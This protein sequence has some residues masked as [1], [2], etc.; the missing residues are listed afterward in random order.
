MV[1]YQL[2]QKGSALLMALF[3]TAISTIITMGLIERQR[4]DIHRSELMLSSNQTYLYTQGAVVWAKHFLSTD[5]YPNANNN[6]SNAESD[7]TSNNTTTA[8]ANRANKIIKWPVVMPT[9]KLP[10]GSTVNAMIMDAQGFYNINNVQDESEQAYFIRL[11]KIILPS[12]AQ[13]NVPDILNALLEWVSQQG[14]G[15][16]INLEEYYMSHLP[17]Y[18]AAHNLFTTISEIR[19]IKGVT[20]Q[21]YNLISPYLIALPEKTS[22]NVNSA[23]GPVLMALSPSTD[24]NYNPQLA[25]QLIALRD[26]NGGFTNVNDFTAAPLVKQLN[27]NTKALTTTS[28]YFLLRVD[29]NY[30]N[31][32]MTLFALLKR[33]L[34]ANNKP[35]VTILWQSIGTN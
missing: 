30:N 25:Q 4:I 14:Q 5:I 8:P 26:Q 10:D 1:K 34:D 29:V 24:T 22:V 9:Q 6:S 31:A 20:P 28:N 11:L 27:I 7:T 2:S 17:P 32:R 19:L 13:Q 21:I 15:S 18:K 33:K 12:G 35:S 3:I 16:N 23:T